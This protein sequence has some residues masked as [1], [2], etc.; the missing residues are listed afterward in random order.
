MKKLIALLLALIMMLGLVACTGNADPTD[1]PTDAPKPTDA[2]ND[3]PT[4]APTEAPKEEITLYYYTTNGIGPTED[5]AEVEAKLSEI[6]DTIPGYEHI[7]IKLMFFIGDEYTQNVTL[8][9]TDGQPIDLIQTYY[10]D[11][12]TMVQ[13]GDFLALDDLMTQF[14]NLMGDVPEWMLDFGKVNGTQ[15]YIPSYQ[16]CTNLR[17]MGF[18]NEYL[19][20]WYDE[21]GKTEED[22]RKIWL[23]KDDEAGV[24]AKLDFLEELC[25]AT[26]KG[27]GKD[28]KWISPSISWEQQGN[29]SEYIGWNYGYMILPEGGRP[30]Y[31]SLNATNK[32]VRARYHEWYEEGLIHPDYPVLAE[33]DGLSTFA[34]AENML[35]DEAFI[36]IEAQNIQSDE[37]VEQLVWGAIPMT[38]FQTT[39]HAYIS[40]QYAAGGNCIYVESEHP[41]ECMMIIELMMNEHGKEFFNTLIF[42]IEGKH[43]EW[44]DKEKER[45]KTLQYDSVNVGGNATYGARAWAN[46][47]SF[48]RWKNQAQADDVYDYI[49]ALH[50]SPDTVPSP[51]MGIFWDTGVVQDKYA[52]CSNVQEEYKYLWARDNFEEAEAE[53]LDK[54]IKAGAQEIADELGRQ[55]DEHIKNKG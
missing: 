1:A 15:Y 46:G 23:A 25:L 42:G 9:M 11:Y 37:V 13:Q 52:Q 44:V 3:D 55:F 32:I 29:N 39:D 6:L 20:Y 18:P 38:S 53:Y 22:V 12:A 49:L 24:N 36:N 40:S 5:V 19:Q 34:N 48:L 8:A 27:S 51:V 43:Y 28:T 31:E 30:E 2:P 54:L 33:N 45:V 41:E 7:N 26:R 14:P 35:N 10:L 47:N 17:H 16:Q 21:T 50:S 4:D